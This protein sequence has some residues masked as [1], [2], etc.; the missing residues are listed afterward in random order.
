MLHDAEVTAELPIDPMGRADMA[1]RVPKTRESLH[2]IGWPEPDG[3][4]EAALRLPPPTATTVLHG[5]LH[6]RHLLV[7]EGALSGVIDFGDI[8]R[9][10]PAID[11]MVC[12]ALLPPEGWAEFHATYG[13]VDE[14]RLLRARVLAL[15][16]CAALVLYAAHEGMTAV[17]EEA[18]TGCGGSVAERVA[19]VEHVF[20]RDHD[21]I[22]A[23]RRVG[24]ID[25]HVGLR[26]REHHVQQP[27]G[28]ERHDQH[29]AR[30]RHADPGARRAPAWPSRRPR[31]RRARARSRARPR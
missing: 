8:C 1:I 27:A 22:A 13:A 11:L 6:L 21:P 10:D 23:E 28:A 17:E 2:A 15:D 25:V 9:G 19:R 16:L 7:H 24:E 3:V 29:L 4:F 5:D 12:W 31:R 20:G 30:V 18:R 14:A 26:E